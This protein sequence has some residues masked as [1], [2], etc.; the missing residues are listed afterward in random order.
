MNSHNEVI[1]GVSAFGH[2]TAASL[3]VKA[4]GEVLYAVAEERLT[5]VKHDSRFPAGGI[6]QCLEKAS[7]LK[8]TLTDVALNFNPIEFTRGALSNEIY[9]LIA[10]RLAADDLIETLQNVYALNEY[11]VNGALSKT[12]IDKAIEKLDCSRATKDI[13]KRRIAF[14]FN[15]AIKYRHIYHSICDLFPDQK[16]HKLNHHLTHAASAF[17]NSGFTKAT[18]IVLDG[19]GESETVSVYL[20]DESG[21]KKVAATSWPCS[22][23]IFYLSATTHLG[24]K[25][26]DEYKVMGMAAYGRPRFYDTLKQMISVSD[27]AELCFHETPYFSMQEMGSSGHIWFTFTKKMADLVP[28]RDPSA[29]IL[30][31]HFDFA[32]SVQKLA[33]DIGVDIARKSIALTGEA[34]IAIAGGVGLNGLMNEQIRKRSGCSDIFIYPAAGDDGTA[35]GAAQLVAFNHSRFAPQRITTCYYGYNPTDQEI[36]AALNSKGLVYS[37]PASIS[38][39]IASALANNKIV[40]RYNARAE[41]GPRALGQRSIMANPKNQKTKDILNIRIKHREPFRPFAPV[42]LR[43]HLGDYFDLDTDAPF[44][45]LICSTKERAKLEIPAVVH[46]DGTA[47]VQTVT[48]TQNSDLY[49]I[50]DEFRKITGTPVIINTSFNVNGETIV[51]TPLDAIESFGFMDIDY[52]AIGNY[53]VSKEE[54]AAKF[55]KISHDDYLQ[56]RRARFEEFLSGPMSALDISYCNENIFEPGVKNTIVRDVKKQIKKSPLLFKIASWVRGVR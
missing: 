18:V 47:R 11:Y 52:L 36:V 13:L 5:N 24:F 25:L 21:L 48:R 14:Y 8:L 4:T 45:L 35:I 43:E 28:P 16:V 51:D 50:I 44:M 46:D 39:T 26:G 20:G 37:K 40:A 38:Q 2:D 53:W 56:I 42:C 49:E 3:V 27:N 54:N 22:L 12:V 30:Q 19:Q 41:F 10:N 32:A 9:R 7:S 34:N 6:K 15:W 1:L 23:G 31:E 33:E 55:A 17:F 29:E